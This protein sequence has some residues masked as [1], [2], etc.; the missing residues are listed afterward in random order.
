M[1]MS[2]SSRKPRSKSNRDTHS[3]NDREE[4]QQNTLMTSSK[5]ASTRIRHRKWHSRSAD[6]ADVSNTSK[7]DSS[8]YIPHRPRRTRISR[9]HKQRVGH[10]KSVCKFIDIILEVFFSV[11]IAPL[12]LLDLCSKIQRKIFT[13]FSTPRQRNVATAAPRPLSRLPSAVRA[14][15]GGALR[16][17]LPNV[18]H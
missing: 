1:C 4:F 11:F 3:N 9:K 7:A 12:Y 17:P 13:R 18:V 10:K 8:A 15:G 6:E 5:P 16:R 2:A 14:S